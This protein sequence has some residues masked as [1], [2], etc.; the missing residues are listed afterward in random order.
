MR[1]LGAFFQS[2][3]L[4]REEGDTRPGGA[5]CSPLPS[6]EPRP[7]EGV[8]RAGIWGLGGTRP[9][10]QFSILPE[11]IPTPP[12]LASHVSQIKASVHSPHLEGVA[13]LPLVVS[14]GSPASGAPGS[15]RSVCGNRAV[16]GGGRA[17]RSQPLPP[18][19]HPAGQLGSSYTGCLSRPGVGRGSHRAR[20]AWSPCPPRLA[21]GMP[22]RGRGGRRRRHR[23]AAASPPPARSRGLVRLA[24]AGEARPR[25]RNVGTARPAGGGREAG[26]LAGW[27]APPHGHPRTLL[28]LPG[29]RNPRP[30]P[31]GLA[32]EPQGPGRRRWGEFA[33]APRSPAPPPAT[34]AAAAAKVY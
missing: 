16:V 4:D 11:I 2:P 15:Q 12:L 32:P 1:G 14:P 30:A 7:W 23:A 29:P 19:P 22:R 20:I 28:W 31:P 17:G 18:H 9:L 33:R 8:G 6:R 3:R 27:R 25:V 13:P 21:V 24:P 26:T 34:A 10:K 5:R